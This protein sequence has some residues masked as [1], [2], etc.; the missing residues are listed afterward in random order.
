MDNNQLNNYIIARTANPIAFLL[1]EIVNNFFLGL[2]YY[3]TKD[4]VHKMMGIWKEAIKSNIDNNQTLSEEDKEEQKSQ[5]DL[6]F[7]NTEQAILQQLSIEG[8]LKDNF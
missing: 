7:S 8:R 2:P 6:I 3:V 4:T 5:T 1:G